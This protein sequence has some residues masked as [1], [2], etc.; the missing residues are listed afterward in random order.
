MV[1][2]WS[3]TSESR[4][5]VGRFGRRADDVKQ[6][7]GTGRG[8]GSPKR[9]QAVFADAGQ[10]L[11]GRNRGSDGAAEPRPEDRVEDVAVAQA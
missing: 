9:L 6:T 11:D 2:R 10:P 3:D 5:L 7:D 4:G 8:R 1:S